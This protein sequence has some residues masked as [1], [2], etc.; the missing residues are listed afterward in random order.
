MRRFGDIRRAR[1][2]RRSAAESLHNL[3]PDTVTGVKLIEFID[4]D[5]LVR[6]HTIQDLR[7]VEARIAQRDLPSFHPAVLNHEH[8]AVKN[9]PAG[10][11]DFGLAL[12]DNDADLAREIRQELLR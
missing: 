11:Q 10:N 6:L 8:K 7:I 3:N 12:T 4:D 1:T 9:R 2:A 5:L